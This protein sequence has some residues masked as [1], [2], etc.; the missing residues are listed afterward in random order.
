MKL[1]HGS[2]CEVAKPDVSHSRGSVDFGRGFYLTSYQEQAVRWAKRKAM[3][4]NGEPVVNAYDFDERLLG[5][6]RARRF[7]CYD[8]EWLDFVCDC[9]IADFPGHEYEVI[10]GPVA[11]DKVFEAVNMYFQGL[12]DAE[13]TLAALAFFERNDQFCFASQRAV[14]ILLRFEGAQGVG[15]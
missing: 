2:N 11:D 9:R 8:P 5:G 3:R 6:F 12:W 1:F 13:T 4:M 10:V 7:E 15:A 14:D